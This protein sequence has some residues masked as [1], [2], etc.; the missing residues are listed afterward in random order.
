MNL[1][2][3]RRCA[4]K[5]HSDL[6]M[7]RHD[8]RSACGVGCDLSLAP[9]LSSAR[10]T[11][12]PDYCKRCALHS[13]L[14]DISGRT[15]HIEGLWTVYGFGGAHVA[16]SDSATFWLLILCTLGQSVLRRRRLL[17]RKERITTTSG[18]NYWHSGLEIPIGLWPNASR[19][20]ARL[21]KARRAYRPT[22]PAYG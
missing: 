18:G 8:S 15:S 2:Q 21:R 10:F 4:R 19:F 1:S 17:P 3:A 20:L 22:C 9:P 12:S 7:T 5:R 14:G 6:R 16:S 13:N 11:A